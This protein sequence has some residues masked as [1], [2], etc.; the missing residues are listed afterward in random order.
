[1]GVQ[2]LLKFLRTNPKTRLQNK[3]L[4]GLAEKKRQESGKRAK[5]VCDFLSVL[6][7]LLKLFH[8]AKITEGSYKKESYLFGGDYVEYSNRF[9]A[10][11]RALL[12]CH[13]EPILFVDGSRGSSLDDF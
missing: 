9:I 11:L 8:E 12:C 13:A 2:G 6:L 4:A 5:I 1:M 10:L 7:W 3:S